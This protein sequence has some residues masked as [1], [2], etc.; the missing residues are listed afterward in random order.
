MT[1]LPSI[2]M[3]FWRRMAQQDFPPMED[4]CRKTTTVPGPD[5]RQCRASSA[6]SGKKEDMSIDIELPE[7]DLRALATA[8]D[9][10]AVVEGYKV[11]IYLRLSTVLGVRM[12][13]NCPK[14]NASRNGLGCQDRFGSNM[15]PMGGSFGGMPAVGGGTEHQG[16]GTPH[17]HAEGHVVCA[18]QFDTMEEVARKFQAADIT[19]EAWKAYNSWLHR[20]DVLHKE[21][22]EAFKQRVDEEFATRFASREHDGLSVAPAYLMRDARNE[23]AVR[24][25]Q[26]EILTVS[27]ATT[28]AQ[29]EQLKEDGQRFVEEYMKDAQFVFSRVQHH[30]HQKTAKGYVPFKACRVKRK[31]KCKAAKL[32]VCKADFPKTKLITFATRLVCRGLAK[33]YGL[34]TQGRRNQLGNM[35][36]K[37]SCEWQSG[38]S[39][40]LAVVFRSNTH[41]LPN[42]RAPLLSCTHDDAASITRTARTPASRQAWQRS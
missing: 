29:K 20:E 12:C 9:P 18:Y 26:G 31:G 38:T 17:F 16:N 14:F 5:G 28:Q 39:P 3:R 22:H 13:P 10:H 8:R 34:R 4:K 7:Y 1:R 32:H 24:G 33:K 30:C 6:M 21:S 19:V 35:V 42:Y 40:A 36:G 23:G 2:T 37:R 25:Q 27:N 15:R 11:H 41:T